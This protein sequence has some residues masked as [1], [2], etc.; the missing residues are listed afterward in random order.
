MPTAKRGLTQAVL[1][2]RL[3]SMR[4]TTA[5]VLAIKDPC[6]RAKALR[7]LQIAITDQRATVAHALNATLAELKDERG[8]SHVDIAALLGFNR[9]TLVSN[10]VLKG[11]DRPRGRWV[12]PAAEVAE[13]R[14]MHDEGYTNQQ[15]AEKFNVHRNT[16]G[17]LLKASNGAAP[18]K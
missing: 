15:I 3:E 9:S 17:R 13:M 4:S 2:Q 11:R 8:M 1:D 14:M 18:S 12:R 6:R 10:R 7:S 16:V 5:G